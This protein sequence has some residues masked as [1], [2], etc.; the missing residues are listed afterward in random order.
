MCVSDYSPANSLWSQ[1]RHTYS[2]AVT[3]S[4][5]ANHRRQATAYISF[6]LR[7][8][9]NP[10]TPTLNDF[11][12]YVQCLANSLRDVR[13]VK[14]YLSGARTYITTAG[15]DPSRLNSPMLSVMLRGVARLSTHTPDP[16]PALSATYVRQ[17]CDLLAMGGP[18]G[19]VLKAALLFGTATLLR[20]S[21][22]LPQSIAGHGPHLIRRR[23]VDRT[24]AGLQVRVNTSKTVWHPSRAWTLEVHKIHNSSYCPVA[25]CHEAWRLAPASPNSLLFLSPTSG[26]PLTAP[27]LAAAMR[28][29][30][31]T[32][33]ACDADRVSVHSLR[34]TGAHLADRAGATLPDLMHHGSW[35]SS[36]VRAYLPA[37]CSSSVPAALAASLALD[38]RR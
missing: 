17:L 20:Q 9:R 5:A 10:M 2:M 22:F 19:R 3:T 32:L 26:Y 8:G 4:T 6:M 7:Y 21:N 30:L 38:P 11:L 31:R 15:G 25:A 16:A 12:M 13:S 33:G 36:A 1:M 18:D 28:A 14:N 27:G 37:P 23:D 35:T 34:R 29:G 24:P